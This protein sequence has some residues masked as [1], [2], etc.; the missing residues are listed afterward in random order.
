MKEK[1]LEAWIMV[2]HLS[3][4]SIK[5]GK[6]HLKLDAIKNDDYYSLINQILREKNVGK[7]GGVAF[8]FDI[9]DFEE[10]VSLLRK[11]YNLKA[12]EE[13]TDKSQKFS[14]VL[15]FDKEMNFL[16]DMTFFT[17]SA[18]VRYFQKFPKKAISENLRKI[19]RRIWF[20]ISMKRKIN[21]TSLTTL[22]V[23]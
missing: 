9:F 13:E 10:V 15:C 21:P 12:S 22:S 17:E 7:K 3:E 11:K 6:D 4:G 2:E 23:R 1:I 20:E 14:F 5:L 16:Q 8:Y 18:Y 19:L